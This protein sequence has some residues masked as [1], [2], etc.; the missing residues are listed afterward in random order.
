MRYAHINS[1]TKIIDNV[2]AADEE[3][4]NTLPDKESWLVGKISS[5]YGYTIAD[6][7]KQ[8]FPEYNIFTEQKYYNSWILDTS[9]LS[10]VP[11]IPYPTSSG[12]YEWDEQNLSWID[13]TPTASSIQ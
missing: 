5:S 11:P 13:V 6:I 3:F 1:I 2:I 4:I 7:G 12:E 9:S 10:W 8:Y